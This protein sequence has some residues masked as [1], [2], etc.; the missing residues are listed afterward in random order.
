MGTVPRVVHPDVLPRGISAPVL[1]TLSSSLAAVHVH[2][3]VAV[4]RGQ[5][6]VTLGTVPLQRRRRLAVP[7]LGAL[8]FHVNVGPVP[9]GR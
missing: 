2:A 4:H 6:E 7:A 9:T 5:E 1:A 8:R 3:P